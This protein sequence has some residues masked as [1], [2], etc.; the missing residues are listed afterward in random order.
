MAMTLIETR[1]IARASEIER[2]KFF[3]RH[4]IKAEQRTILPP[5][6]QWEQLVRQIME[7]KQID[8]A[9]A[10]KLARKARPEL[11]AAMVRDANK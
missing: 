5:R 6:Q 1:I 11:L 10:S 7:E 9:A 2:K 3:E 8:K 4:G